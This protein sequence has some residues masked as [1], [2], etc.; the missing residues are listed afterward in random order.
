M[1]YITIIPVV[2]VCVGAVAALIALAVR[3]GVSG[4]KLILLGI[5]ITLLGGIAAIDQ[6]TNLGGIEYLIAVIG[7]SKG[8]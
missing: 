6:N 8:E 7:A 3:K 4:L 1:G 5:N 2:I